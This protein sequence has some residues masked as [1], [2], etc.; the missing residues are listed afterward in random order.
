[1]SRN[2]NLYD[3]SLRLRRDVL[4]FDL[5]VAL[6]GTAAL[7]L[8]LGI[9]LSRWQLS[10]TADVA[11][12]GA[13]ELLPQQ[14]AFKA[15]TERASS[16]P[17]QALQSEIARAQ[18]TLLQRRSALQSLDVGGLGR[19]A[20]FS[21]HLEALARQSIDGLWLTGMVLRQ[22][23]VLLRGRALNPA[24]IPAYV[25]RLE[26]EPS[27]QGRGFK[28]LEVNRPLDE[29][30]KAASQP[31]QGGDTPLPVRAEFVEFKLTGSNHD[32]PVA[33]GARP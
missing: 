21:T 8:A 14:A 10:A 7:C 19:E 27:L 5:A 33:P 12:R 17:D 32:E 22:D 30:A 20:G 26:R 1:M 31:A 25:Q 28:A 6:I 16:K 15:M 11:A 18:H 2:I 3:P 4:G 23:D 24:L 13:A 9:G 29:P